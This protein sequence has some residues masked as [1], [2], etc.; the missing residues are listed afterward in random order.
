MSTADLLA[1]LKLK[2]A[3]TC[4]NGYVRT[5]ETFNFELPCGRKGESK[6]FTLI[7]V[8]KKALKINNILI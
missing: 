4:L 3:S 5:V 2:A 6:N 8:D 1:K 7:V